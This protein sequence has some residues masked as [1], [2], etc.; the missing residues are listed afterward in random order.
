[1]RYVVLDARAKWHHMPSAVSV[2]SRL[3]DRP[4]P[5][6]RLRGRFG[7]EPVIDAET[8]AAERRARLAARGAVVFGKAVQ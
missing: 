7:P 6:G 5:D 1:M 8:I 3:G 2:P 4:R